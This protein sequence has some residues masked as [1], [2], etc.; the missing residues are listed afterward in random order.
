MGGGSEEITNILQHRTEKELGLSLSEFE[1]LLSSFE[2]PGKKERLLEALEKDVAAL[3]KRRNN[4]QTYF[5]HFDASGILHNDRES[6]ETAR[7]LAGKL[8][9]VD[10]PSH[11]QMET[12]LPYMR[13]LMAKADIM[14]L[15]KAFTDAGIT[16]DNLHKFSEEDIENKVF[17]KVTNDDPEIG[18]VTWDEA[19]GKETVGQDAK[20]S[21]GS[22]S[23]QIDDSS[24]KWK[25]DAEHDEQWLQRQLATKYKDKNGSK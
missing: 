10:A 23:V 14:E 20:L 21:Q 5:H 7:Q 15:P 13:K 17:N 9:N 11:E 24:I 22:S 6:L 25:W 12:E 19:I 1:T 2:E 18:G 8:A 16:L 3:E 4:S